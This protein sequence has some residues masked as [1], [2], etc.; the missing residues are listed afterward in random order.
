MSEVQ[1]ASSARVNPR[2]FSCS[3]FRKKADELVDLHCSGPNIKIEP[4]WI[5]SMLK[6]CQS[7]HAAKVS[8]TS[9]LSIAGYLCQH[10][11]SR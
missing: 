4:L 5:Y 3:Q 11:D 7:P 9:E 2:L 1:W 6:R 10:F 8:T